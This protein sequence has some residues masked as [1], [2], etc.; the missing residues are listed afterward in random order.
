MS[1]SAAWTALRPHLNA[2]GLDPVRIEVKGAL[3]VPDVNLTTGWVEMKFKRNAPKGV[4]TKL[5]VDHFTIEQ[6]AWLTRRWNARTGGRRA[7]VVL[8][9]QHPK[10]IWLLIQGD[11]AARHLGR[12]PLGQLLLIA[13]VVGSHP[14]DLIG[15]LSECPM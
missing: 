12:V 7:W 13:T 2:A 14:S 8:Y 4:E 1:E 6:R 5:E 3:G 10:P 11:R 9:V 15:K